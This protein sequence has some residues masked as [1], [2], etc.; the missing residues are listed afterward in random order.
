ML[1]GGQ[2]TDAGVIGLL[3]AHMEAFGSGGLTTQLNDKTQ[4]KY[5]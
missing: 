4:M 2:T 1:T 5:M 3:I